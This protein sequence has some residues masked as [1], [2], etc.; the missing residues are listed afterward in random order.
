MSYLNNVFIRLFA[1]IALVLFSIEANAQVGLI[2]NAIDKL[3]GCKNF[4]YQYNEKTLDYTTDT[5]TKQHKDIFQKAPDDKF[6]GYLFNRQTQETGKSYHVI[7]LYNGQNLISIIPEDSTYQFGDIKQYAML[8]STSTLPGLLKWLKGRPEKKPSEM[9][10]D[11]TINGAISHHSVFHIYDTTINKEH[12]HT[13]IDVFINKLSGLP[14]CITIREKVLLFGKATNYY[15]A[16][17]YSNYKLNQDAIDIAAITVPKGF[18]PPKNQAV[19]PLITPGTVAP[20]W[21]LYTTDGKQISLTQ[22]KGKVILMDF[23]FIGCSGCMASLQSLDRVYE[24]YKDQK[25][26]LVSISN[27]DSRQTVAG[28]K[29]K[30]NI[31]NPVCGDGADVAKAYHLPGAPLFYFI[32]KEGKIA[33]A[34]YGYDDDFELK[35]TSLIDSLLS[36]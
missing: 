19:L 28:F 24:K 36:K 9:A 14:D 7:D 23:F 35:T 10:G 25:F 18:H 20:D 21:T 22:L 30:Y 3:E 6:F 33:K 26:V 12:Y 13:D 1:C 11:T 2:Q 16:Y 15:I 8:F 17:Q 32:D 4:S 31:K 5:T 34:T 27:R 29:K